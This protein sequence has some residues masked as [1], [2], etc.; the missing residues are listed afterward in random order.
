MAGLDPRLSGTVY[1]FMR[2]LAG[3]AAFVRVV[4]AARRALQPSRSQIQA[5][6]AA[7]LARLAEAR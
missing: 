3:Q 2:G 4:V 1:A 6:L 5:G 7:A